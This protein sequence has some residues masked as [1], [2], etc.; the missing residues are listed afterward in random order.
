MVEPVLALV[1]APGAGLR[2]LL[3]HLR[4]MAPLGVERVAIMFL[5]PR[6][7]ALA[8]PPVMAASPA[9]VAPKTSTSSRRFIAILLL[10]RNMVLVATHPEWVTVLVASIIPQQFPARGFSLEKSPVFVFHVVNPLDTM[11]P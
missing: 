8:P 2:A 10:L 3:L 1:H 7:L 11:L 6:L 5:G 4:V 9:A